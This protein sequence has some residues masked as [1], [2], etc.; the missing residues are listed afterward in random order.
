MSKITVELPSKKR[1][2]S[3]LRAEAVAQ[4]LRHQLSSASHWDSAKLCEFLIEWQEVTHPKVKWVRPKPIKN[5]RQGRIIQMNNQ[6][7]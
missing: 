5:K 7:D 2:E 6:P 4:E 3:L 1:L